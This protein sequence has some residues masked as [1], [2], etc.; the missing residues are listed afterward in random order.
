MHPV[1][2]PVPSTS[3]HLESTFPKRPESFF[4]EMKPCCHRFHDASEGKE[5]TPLA[6]Q[7]RLRFEERDHSL[8]EVLPSTD[9]IHQSPI[10]RAAMI[11]ADAAT[12]ETAHDEVQDLA[13]FG[14]LAHMELRHEL[15]AGPR[16]RV[17]LKRNVERPFAVNIAGD[18]SIR[19]FLLIIRT[20][21]IVT[22][23]ADQLMRPV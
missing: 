11:L 22:V 23:H 9:D 19:S 12:S 16:T 2:S 10:S 6:A 4:I 1:H 15:P 3:I 20:E 5:V 14:I 17:P 13:T 18:I 7:Q 21:R 8:Q